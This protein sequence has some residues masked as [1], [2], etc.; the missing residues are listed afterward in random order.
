MQVAEQETQAV[1]V[2]EAAALQTNTTDEIAWF[3]FAQRFATAAAASGYFADANAM[4]QALMKIAAGRELGIAPFVALAGINIIKGRPVLTGELIGALLQSQGVTWKF[5]QHDAA[6][7]VLFL[8]RDG[9]PMTNQDGSHATVAFMRED[10]ERAGL[11]E[12]QGEKKDKPSMYDKYGPDMYY[13]RC[14]VRVQRRFA[15]GA[16]KGIPVLTV[17]EAAEIATPGTQGALPQRKEISD[18]V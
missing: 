4:P 11:L 12:K 9:R 5:G 1:T 10:A 13:N 18:A 16:T 3:E 15:P 14:I 6:G 17:D 7:C 8:Y 2:Y